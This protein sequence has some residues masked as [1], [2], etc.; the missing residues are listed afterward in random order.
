MPS[1]LQDG[2]VALRVQGMKTYI[3][4]LEGEVSA[5]MFGK[6]VIQINRGVQD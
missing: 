1:A 4:D 3:P 2:E 6:I 5:M